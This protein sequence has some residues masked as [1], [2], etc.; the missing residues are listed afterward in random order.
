MKSLNGIVIGLLISAFNL[1]PWI[2]NRAAAEPVVINSIQAGS[3]P[4]SETE[5]SDPLA[6]A[7]SQA[8]SYLFGVDEFEAGPLFLAA[9]PS[10]PGDYQGN[11]IAGEFEFKLIESVVVDMSSV[12]FTADQAAVVGGLESFYA[13]VVVGVMTV[14]PRSVVL[15]ALAFP[16]VVEGQRRNVL[17]PMTTD[18]YD[19]G[20]IL[21][22]SVVADAF[23]RTPGGGT[24]PTVPPDPSGGD[25]AACLAALKACDDAYSDKVNA[26]K[27]RL[28]LCI[29]HVGIGCMAGLLLAVAFCIASGGILCTFSWWLAA[30]CGTTLLGCVG[31]FVNTLIDATLE[32]GECR[33]RVK[34]TPEC[35]RSNNGTVPM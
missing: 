12:S 26:A 27:A 5:G 15:G 4:G 9:E 29:G 3:T 10:A 16:V 25:S 30:T 35:I 28:L 8:Q 34:R 21:L 32:N 19:D 20:E 14:G 7:N 23:L 18:L 2:L 33:G 11:T 31:Y 17:L 6:A 13:R 22:T 1:Q 24:T